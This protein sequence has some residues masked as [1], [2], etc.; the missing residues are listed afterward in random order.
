MCF[1]SATAE[2]VKLALKAGYRNIDTAAAYFNEKEVGEGI[3]Q[4]MEE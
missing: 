2:C 1:Q 3:R 4:A